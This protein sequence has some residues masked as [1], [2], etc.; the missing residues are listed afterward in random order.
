MPCALGDLGVGET[1]DLA[2]QQRLARRLGQLADR[3]RQLRAQLLAR[4]RVDRAARAASASASGARRQRG[5]LERV[6]FAPLDAALGVLAAPHVD[7]LVRHEPVEPGEEARALLEATQRGVGLHEGLLHRVARAPPRCAGC[8]ARGGRRA[9][10]SARR[11]RER[12]RGRPPRARRTHS[13]SSG[14]AGAAGAPARGRLR[15]SEL[16]I[17][18]HLPR[19]PVD[20]PAFDADRGAW[21][22][23]A[24]RGPGPV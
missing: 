22:I 9:P 21:F 10:G 3:R 12:R 8:G 7:A 14:P 16:R 18:R 17:G 24:P 5:L 23:R 15:W 13:P 11:A 4:Q 20:P 6:A 1:V 19:S 2:Q